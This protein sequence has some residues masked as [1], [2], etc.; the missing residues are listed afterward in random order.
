MTGIGLS[1]KAYVNMARAQADPAHPVYD[2]RLLEGEFRLLTVSSGDFGS[3]IICSLSRERLVE[4]SSYDALSY[5]WGDATRSE[6]NT[7]NGKRFQTT[8]NVHEALQYLRQPD[9][10]LCIWIDQVQQMGL[11]YERAR[12]TRVWLG[13]LTPGHES[14]LEIAVEWQNHPGDEDWLVEH[15]GAI[16]HVFA[17]PWFERVWVF[18][19]VALAQKCVVALGHT[20]CTLGDLSKTKILYLGVTMEPGSRLAAMDQDS[21]GISGLWGTLLNIDIMNDIMLDANPSG[22]QHTY[23]ELL[24]NGRSRQCTNPRDYIYGIQGI[25]QKQRNGDST[26]PCVR[27]DYNDTVAHTFARATVEGLMDPRGLSLN[28]LAMFHNEADRGTECPEHEWRADLP[29]WVPDWSQ[30]APASYFRSDLYAAGGLVRPVITPQTFSDPAAL[31]RL[32][33]IRICSVET[34]TPF[35]DE[36]SQPWRSEDWQRMEAQALERGMPYGD[37]RLQAFAR[38]LLAD[39][40]ID[41][42][43]HGEQRSRWPPE[44]CRLDLRPWLGRDHMTAKLR[45]SI[46]DARPEDIERKVENLSESFWLA[47]MSALV[48]RSLLFADSGQFAVGPLTARR[49]DEIVVLPSVNMPFILRRKPAGTTYEMVGPAYVHGVM[50]GEMVRW[51]KYDIGVHTDRKG[52]LVV[53]RARKRGYEIQEYVIE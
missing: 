22:P 8:K 37:N 4:P 39:T 20:S 31:L 45:R 49:G 41:G 1:Q 33:G 42:G 9:C 51:T 6:C 50:D 17:R 2:A 15:Y 53:P 35:Y 40:H 12:T 5:Y 24:M 26:V 19:E 36:K 23:L 25:V 10:P 43:S 21:R 30:E 38:T 48:G 52:F 18:Q 44:D 27:V 28:E 29:S 32:P 13:A 3:P 11:V 16:S 14:A 47:S 34:A 7:I 46:P